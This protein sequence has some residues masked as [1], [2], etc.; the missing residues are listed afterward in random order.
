MCKPHSML[1]NNCRAMQVSD[2]GDESSH[3]AEIVRPE[4]D[5]R[6]QVV[7]IVQSADSA[8]MEEDCRILLLRLRNSFIWRFRISCPFCTEFLRHFFQTRYYFDDGCIRFWHF[9]VGFLKPQRPC[10]ELSGTDPFAA[11]LN[12]FADYFQQ[13]SLCDYESS[14]RNG[15]RT[16]GACSLH[17][18]CRVSHSPASNH[19]NCTLVKLPSDYNY[20]SILILHRCR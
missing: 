13:C 7:Q 6:C 12:G 18:A 1:Q 10:V 8:N 17:C 19:G 11:V 3:F 2:S 5:H 14:R 4:I 16:G 9:E 15:L 20:F